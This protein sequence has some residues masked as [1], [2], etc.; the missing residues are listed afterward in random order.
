MGTIA[1]F[2]VKPF[3]SKHLCKHLKWV[4]LFSTLTGLV[5]TLW[6]Q[7]GKTRTFQGLGHNDNDQAFKDKDKDWTCKDK[8]K[9]KDLKLVLKESLRT[10]TSIPVHDISVYPLREIVNLALGSCK[11]CILYE[12]ARDL[13]PTRTKHF[14]LKTVITQKWKLSFAPAK[15]TAS[16]SSSDFNPTS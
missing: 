15:I 10:R 16:S 7:L 4:K 5:L 14:S 8:A 11:R 13:E 6:M 1:D 2:A 12:T 9:N 3:S